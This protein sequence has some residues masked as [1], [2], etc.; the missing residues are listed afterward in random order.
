MH[1]TCIIDTGRWKES[2][3]S[4]THAD[5]ATRIDGIIIEGG[6]GWSHVETPGFRAEAQSKSKCVALKIVRETDE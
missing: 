4:K 5:L 1:W 3:S 6:R 2:D